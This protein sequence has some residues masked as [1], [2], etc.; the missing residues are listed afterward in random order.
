MPIT[1]FF[2]AIACIARGAN[3]PASNVCFYF[4]LFFSIYLFILHFELFGITSK[5]F[6]FFFLSFLNTVY[7]ISIIRDLPVLYSFSFLLKNKQTSITLMKGFFN[8]HTHKKS[9]Y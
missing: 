1:V 8:T 9:S 5:V 4:Y 3:L 7:R 2:S 6:L